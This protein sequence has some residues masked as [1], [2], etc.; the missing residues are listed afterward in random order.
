MSS[1]RL[2]LCTDMD[3]TLIPNGLATE[4]EFAR[5][6]FSDFVAEPEIRLVYVTGRDR[7]LVMQAIV[8]YNLPIPDYVIADVGTKI[9]KIKKSEWQVLDEWTQQIDGDWRGQSRLDLQQLL[10][11]VA[12]LTLQEHEKQNQH[13][14]SYYVDLQSDRKKILD[15]IQV[16]F[17][18]SGIAANLVWSLDDEKNQ[19]LLDILPQSA[20]KL[21]AVI[22]LQQRLRYEFGEVL[23]AGDSGNDLDVLASLIPSVLV[24]NASDEVRDAAKKSACDSGNSSALYCADGRYLTMNGNYAAGILEGVWH[25]FSEY[26]DHL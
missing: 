10:A 24:A 1:R 21:H 18:K 26:R 20:N 22:F 2:L 19:G 23:F 16:F 8:D 14:L 11:E 4:S 7:Q 13:K 3:R 9:Y 12:G 6:R 17:D 5:Q 25:F 15:K